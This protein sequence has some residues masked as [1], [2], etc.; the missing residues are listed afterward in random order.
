MKVPTPADAPSFN[1]DHHNNSNY[2]NNYH[3]HHWVRDAV[4]A[5]NVHHLIN[6]HYAKNILVIHIIHIII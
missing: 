1:N 3:K 5:G 2:S 4:V 6:R